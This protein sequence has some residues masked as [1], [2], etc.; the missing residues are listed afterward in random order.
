MPFNQMT[1]HAHRPAHSALLRWP[2][3]ADMQAALLWIFIASGW[4]VVVEPAPYEF[5]FVLTF[6]LFLPGGLVASVFTAPMII[7]LILY[8]IGGFLSSAQLASLPP[9]VAE[10][11]NRFVFISSYMAATSLF[12]AMA[13]T[14]RPERIAGIVR[15]AWIVAGVIAATLGMIGYF[16]IAGMGAKWAPIQ[17]AQGTFKDPNVLSTFLVAP[18]IFLAQDF[19]L[20]NARHPWLRGAALLVILGG[21]F[22][23]FSRGAWAVTVGS[24]LLLALFTF[25]TTTRTSLRR[26]IVMMAALLTVLGAVLLV[27][28]LSVPAV[29]EMFAERFTL[30]KDYDAGETG[31]FARQLRSIP[32]LLERPLGFGPFGFSEIF[33]EDPHNVYINAFSA[34]GWLGGISYLLLTFATIAIGLRAMLI[35][36]PWRRHVIA[37]FAPLLML[38]LQGMQI[39]TD[40]WRHFYLLLGMVWGL[41][42]AS[43][44]WLQRQR[45]Q[46]HQHLQRGAAPHM[47]GTRASH[48]QRQPPPQG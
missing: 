9:H 48:E 30:F 15:H 28:L 18:A 22:L 46:H 38:I 8:N 40:H 13:A 43:E 11:A 20:G 39:D 31:R 45:R 26:R 4:F 27:A 37:F 25:I 33:G 2:T 42:A 6:A 24:M 32:M 16:D 7:F 12:F 10:K 19:M 44:L 14:A 5:L 35:P 1:A 29:R 34:Y 21:I 36:T 23:A 17:R 47:T 41:Y 3:V